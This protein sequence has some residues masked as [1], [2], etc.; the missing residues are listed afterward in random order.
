[1]QRSRPAGV[2]LDEANGILNRS[3]LHRF[4]V[5]DVDPEL[6]LRE[7]QLDEGKRVRA[8]VL[9][10]RRSRRQASLINIK[11]LPNDAKGFARNALVHLIPPDLWCVCIVTATVPMSQTHRLRVA[12]LF[13]GGRARWIGARRAFRTSAAG[14]T[15]SA[16][17]VRKEHPQ[18]GS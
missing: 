13:F 1:M 9:D 8:Q 17:P 15:P 7:R 4:L 5:G 18:T 12:V 10:E 2:L 6:L 16:S 3:D 14:G 11:L